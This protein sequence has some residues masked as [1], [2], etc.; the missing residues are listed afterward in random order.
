M[1]P[2][3]EHALGRE[4]DVPWED[5]DVQRWIAAATDVF[6]TTNDHCSRAKDGAGCLDLA[7]SLMAS[8]G[9]AR[10][11][12]DRIVVSF[13]DAAVDRTLAAQARLA[14]RYHRDVDLLDWMEAVHH[15]LAGFAAWHRVAPRYAAA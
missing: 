10:P 3:V 4:V 7:Q 9:F 12:A 1:L 5:G 14:E 13:H 11:E 8:C 2:L 6:M 15:L